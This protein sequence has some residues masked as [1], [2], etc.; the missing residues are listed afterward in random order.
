MGST[1]HSQCHVPLLIFYYYCCIYYC[2]SL[3]AALFR[4]MC[5]S[6]N[7]INIPCTW[8][9]IYQVPGSSCCRLCIY[10]VYTTHALQTSQPEAGAT[11]RLCVHLTASWL[12]TRTCHQSSVIRGYSRAVALSL[13]SYVRTRYEYKV[14]VVLYIR[15]SCT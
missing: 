10:F 14:I 12:R 5:Q 8:G 11:L 6:C 13:E 1:R 7:N 15:N 3:E 2:C 9:N 4:C